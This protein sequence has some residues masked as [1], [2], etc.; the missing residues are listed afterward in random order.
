MAT[1]N[2]FVSYLEDN[3]Q[4]IG[5]VQAK[6]M[7]GGYG[8]FLEGLMFALIADKTLFF[9]VDNESREEFEVLGLEAF[10]YS[11]KGKTFSMSYYQSPEEALEDIDVLAEWGNKAYGAALRAAAKKNKNKKKTKK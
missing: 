6:R 4:L 11:K 3:L 1:N 7:F 8:L 2:E 5:P 10:T 9:K